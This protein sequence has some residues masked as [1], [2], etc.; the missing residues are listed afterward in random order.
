MK[1]EDVIW[2]HGFTCLACVKGWYNGYDVEKGLTM[3]C[4]V[5]G[6]QAPQSMTAAEMNSLVRERNRRL[7]PEEVAG[8]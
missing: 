3:P 4:A 8:K 7:Y 1:P 5:C 2:L 6:H